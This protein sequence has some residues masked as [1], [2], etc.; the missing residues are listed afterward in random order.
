MTKTGTRSLIRLRNI[1]I[2]AR[3]KCCWSSKL[4]QN[5]K[6]EKFKIKEPQ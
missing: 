1:L 4:K 2:T 6:A 3:F 5:N